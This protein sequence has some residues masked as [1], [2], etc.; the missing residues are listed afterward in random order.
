MK[1]RTRW[2]V[3]HPIQF[4]YLL[5]VVA[6]TLLPCLIVGS[7]LYWLVFQLMAEQIAFPEAVFANLVPVIQRINTLLILVLPPI[8]ALLLWAAI[9]SS[10]R[11]AG[12]IERLDS[13]LERILKGDHEHRI[14]M[15]KNDDLK[16]IAEKINALLD[17][18]KSR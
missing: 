12:P 4:K 11:F 1:S 8:L 15:R 6:A 10:H 16:Q 9:V 5:I 3:N 7:A 13:E 14:R 17:Q 18:K 2:V